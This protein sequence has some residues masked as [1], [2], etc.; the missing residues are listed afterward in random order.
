MVFY[1]GVSWLIFSIQG[2]QT[3]CASE[4]HDA[5]GR[6]L[7]TS[8]NQEGKS[9]HFDPMVGFFILTVQDPQYF[10]PHSLQMCYVLIGKTIHCII[11]SIPYGRKI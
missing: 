9:L 3:R 5:T 8:H 10:T 7:K 6:S 1:K 11:I 2:I 4:N